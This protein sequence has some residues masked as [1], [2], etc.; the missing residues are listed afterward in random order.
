MDPIIL[1]VII[2]VAIVLSVGF[3]LF[4]FSIVPALNE[5]KMLLSDLQR[6]SGEARILISKLNEVTD[7]VNQDLD[8]VDS[9]LDASKETVETASKSLR[10]INKNVLK[11]SAS[12]FA[13][14]PAV[15]LGW[16]IVKKFKG[17][18]S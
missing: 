5:L 16:N 2:I 12:I 4:I 14:L 6:T 13:L 7:K 8:K 9:I 15:K 1:V 18:K 3:L 17:G 11:N 10:F